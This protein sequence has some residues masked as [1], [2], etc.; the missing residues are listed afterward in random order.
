MATTWRYIAAL[1]CLLVAAPAGADHSYLQ[2]LVERA[3]QQRLADHPEWRTLLHYQPRL[4][5]RGVESL[6]D[7]AAFFNSP[8]GRHDPD[9]E[10]EATL[11]AFFVPGVEDE[12]QQPAQC[13][14]IARYVWLKEKLGFDPARLPEAP[15]RRYRAFREAL[16]PQGATLIFASA[17]LNN[18]ASM[19]GH[20][21]LRIDRR[22]QDERTRL[23]A[24]T[25][26][27]AAH[28][29]DP[30]GLR[31]AWRGLTGGYRGRFTLS[32]YFEKVRDYND[33]EHRDLWE[34]RLT[35]TPVELDRLVR[36]LWELLPS[37]YDYY[38]FDENCSYHLLSLL[39]VARPGLRLTDRFHVWTIPSDT[40]HAVARTPALVGEVIY[41]PS[42]ASR[43]RD[44]MQ[45]L[46]AGER[47]L[48]RQMGE[49]RRPDNDA[50][51]L[52]QAPAS[53]AAVL[54]AATALVSYR[55]ER[56]IIHAADG[57]RLSSALLLA[58]SRV[59]DVGPPSPAPAPDSRPDVGHG[60]Q[61]L[62]LQAGRDQGGG[63]AQVEWRAGYHD[64][65]DASRGF[66]PGAQIEVLRLAIRHRED[67][68][69]RL[70][71]LELLDVL[72]LP[73]RDENIRTWAW[74][75]QAGWKREAIPGE[76]DP[77]VFRL[78]MGAGMAFGNPRSN[79][80]AMLEGAIKA[81]PRFEP[82]WIA[83]A[84]PV[85]GWVGEPS[86]RWRVHAWARRSR[87]MDGPRH[88]EREA[89]VAIQTEVARHHGLR[90][91]SGRHTLF[92]R[93]G[94]VLSLGWFYYY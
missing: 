15:C 80:Y 11:A 9:A 52:R 60:S 53:R 18:P 22:G 17:F 40:V 59:D 44:R 81:D 2:E 86:P 45:R 24:P 90:L 67:G 61:R 36:H 41:R 92:D 79:P 21:L 77:L 14:F 23:L 78:R 49:G 39:E 25:I 10:L 32:P 88:D 74:R 42:T 51:L 73:A 56:Q 43:L 84:G 26:N 12:K 50:V 72:S 62:G 94:R 6:N 47:E 89:M 27:Y 31:Y 54:D 1:V 70:H 46:P 76:G 4:F 13:R 63:F 20:T 83:G 48:A 75:L 93:G 85:I 29:T 71:E 58:R 30:I 66:E 38:F 5:G 55:Q 16:D 3:R 8:R 65:L 28:A 87:F 64:L 82:D 37:Y 7:D 19:F 57:E 33:L 69:T 34:Y 35:L 91:E 68:E